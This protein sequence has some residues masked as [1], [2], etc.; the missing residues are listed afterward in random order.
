MSLTNY[1]MLNH[2]IS[3]HSNYSVDFIESIYPYER[4]IYVGL[5]QRD[6]ETNNQTL[7]NN[8]LSS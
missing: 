6:A 2:S 8:I 3:Q 1:Y 4:D 7:A 5:L